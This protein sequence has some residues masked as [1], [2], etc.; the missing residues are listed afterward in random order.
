MKTE[1]TLKNDRVMGEMKKTLE[2]IQKEDDEKKAKDEA[3][4]RARLD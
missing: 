2:R 1:A 4:Q 3:L